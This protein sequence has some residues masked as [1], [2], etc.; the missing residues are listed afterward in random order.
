MILDGGK[1]G[2]GAD[3]DDGPP[4]VFVQDGPAVHVLVVWGMREGGIVDV[5]VVRRVVVGEK[6]KGVDG[7]G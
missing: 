2:R 7:N 3:E 4:L 5:Y 6:G 1:R